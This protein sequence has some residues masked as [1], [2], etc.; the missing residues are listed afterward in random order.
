M[1]FLSF[2]D[3][4]LKLGLLVAKLDLTRKLYR[5]IKQFPSF[6]RQ[7][8]SLVDDEHDSSIVEDDVDNFAHDAEEKEHL[9][10]HA[11]PSAELTSHTAP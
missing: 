6:T 7:A 2:S 8:I 9:A 5:L 1:T 3:K 4:V 11:H 10:I